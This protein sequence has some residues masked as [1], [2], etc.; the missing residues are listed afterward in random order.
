MKGSKMA[1]QQRADLCHGI[2][3]IAA[4][5]GLT[6]RQAK[7]LHERRQLPTFK[8]GRNVCG[9]RSS[10]DEWL[11]QAEAAGAALGGEDE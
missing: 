9:R 1:E 7:H 8:L 10:L 6:E 11:R 5:I 4:H 3:E 2:K